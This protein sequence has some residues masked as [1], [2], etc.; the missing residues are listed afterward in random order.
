MSYELST[1]AAEFGIRNP[2]LI[3]TC[4]SPAL[5]EYKITTN[6]HSVDLTNFFCASQK[7][8]EQNQKTSKDNDLNYTELFQSILHI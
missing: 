8:I 6:T 4:N 7:Q 2:G 3:P 5:H 1:Q